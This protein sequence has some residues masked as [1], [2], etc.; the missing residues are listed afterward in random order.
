MVD[1][2]APFDVRLLRTAL[3]AFVTGVTV[4]TTQD[5]DGRPHGLT[6]NSFNTVSLEPPLVLWSQAKKAGSYEVFQKAEDFA[7]SILAEDQTETAARFAARR[8]DKFDG[9]DIN[10][11][12][13]CLPVIGIS[14]AWLYCRTVS[15]VDGGDHT[16]YIG[17]I[18]KIAQTGRRPLVFGGGQYL[19]TQPHYSAAARLDDL[20]TGAWQ[21]HVVQ[22]C[23]PWMR[24][25]A[26]ELDVTISAA[27]WGNC[28]PTVVGWERGAT[29]I[30]PSFPLGLVLPVTSSATGKIFASFLPD[31]VVAP[32]IQ[33][34]FDQRAGAQSELA[35]RDWEAMLTQVRANGWASHAAT[36]FWNDDLVV[37]AASVPVCDWQGQA[38]VAMGAV[39]PVDAGQDLLNRATGR[40]QEASKLIQ[41]QLGPRPDLMSTAPV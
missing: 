20:P 35:V 12:F 1:H 33:R 22:A 6:A 21:H 10:H 19:L 8:E 14:S 28:G 30:L 5:S 24:R 18:K 3:G 40:L 31:S 36:R 23:G 26:E 34:E 25:L 7:I 2:A 15:R 11:S 32:F 29:S 9:V 17:E 16:I 39:L 38:I 13:C 4:I 37:K 27:V 41:K